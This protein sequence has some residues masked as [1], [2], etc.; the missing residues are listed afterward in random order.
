[1]ARMIRRVGP[2]ITGG[3]PL[4]YNAAMHAL[5][6]L[7]LAAG[8]PL[9]GGL[10]VGGD[11]PS[12][13]TLAV[14][15][16]QALSPEPLDVSGR[17]GKVRARGVRLDRILTRFGFSSGPMANDTAVRDKRAGWKKVVRA[18]AADGFEAVF[19]CAELTEGMGPTR[20]YVVFELDGKPLPPEA[21][22]FRLVVVTDKEPSRSLRQLVRLEVVDLRS[23]AH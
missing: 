10:V 19:S 4:G 6:V 1:M 12:K 8:A 22:P 21:G 14:A 20:A 2:G 5:I 18:T 11:L 23:P 17:S 9:A 3:V 15:D 7:A 13:G 16:L